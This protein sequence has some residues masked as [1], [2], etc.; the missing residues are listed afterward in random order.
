MV[1]SRQSLDPLTA[2]VV[3]I[4]LVGKRMRCLLRPLGMTLNKERVTVVHHPFITAL[5]E[6]C[7]ADLRR[8]ADR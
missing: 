5:A 8:Q 6:P 2:L 7:Q 3:L 4:L 1:Q